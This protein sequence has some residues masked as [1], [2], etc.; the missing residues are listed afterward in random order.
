M[1]RYKSLA[2]LL[3]LSLQ[4]LPGHS[5]GL[6]GEPIRLANGV[7]DGDRFMG[8]ELLGSLSLKG[9]PALAELSGLAWDEDEQTLLAVSDRGWL[10]W[11]KPHFS[12]GHLSQVELTASYPLRD[13]R[14]APLR[15]GWRDA[16]GLTLEQSAN[17]IQGDTRLI[18]SFE[19][20]HRIESYRPDGRWLATL[21]LPARLRETGYRPKSNRSLEAVT[22]HP[23]HGLVTGPESPPDGRPP[24][25]ANYLINAAGQVWE[26]AFKE[27]DG[28]L[29]ALEALPNGDLILLERAYTSIFS[30][31]VISLTRIRATDLATGSTMDTETIARFDSGQGWLMQNMEG[32]TR[33][34][35]MRFF[36]VSD[37]G[38][39]PWAQTQLLY[40][41]IVSE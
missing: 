29:V 18:V 20:R 1:S 41:R 32:L 35:E 31:W 27:P 30:P 24:Y 23:Q 28:A 25:L 38:S 3:I 33:H 16:E 5:A 17:G 19:R 39:L 15:S 14:E 26:Y 22:L 34:R 12:E 36:M 37:D 10:L 4:G 6:V 8:V 9:D 13:R 2:L 11:L 40:F 7:G 21:P